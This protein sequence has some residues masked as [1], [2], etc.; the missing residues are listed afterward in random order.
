MNNIPGS[1][2]NASQ[3]FI[4]DYHNWNSRYDSA[5]NILQTG[6]KELVTDSLSNYGMKLKLENLTMIKYIKKLYK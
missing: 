6:V 4:L 1:S 5:G 2:N 3:L